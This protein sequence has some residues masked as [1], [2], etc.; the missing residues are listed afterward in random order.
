MSMLWPML[1]DLVRAADQ[2]QSEAGTTRV[3]LGPAWRADVRLTVLAGLRLSDEHGNGVQVLK[4][5]MVEHDWEGARDALFEEM[6]ASW[7]FHL[8]MKVDKVLGMTGKPVP[9]CVAR[10]YLFDLT[11]GKIVIAQSECHGVEHFKG[12]I[13]RAQYVALYELWTLL[14]RREDLNTALMGIGPV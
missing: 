13:P 12:S 14:E 3:G 2:L 7:P 4:G 8:D 10:A 9:V 1:E 6:Q 5:K 11:Q